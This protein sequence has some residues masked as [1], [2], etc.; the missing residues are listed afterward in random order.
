MSTPP[1]SA[2]SSTTSS[3]IQLT[4]VHG[5]DSLGAGGRARGRLYDLSLGLAPGIHAVIGRPRDGTSALCELIAG[6]ARPRSGRVLVAGREPWKSPALRRRIGAYLARPSLADTG[7]VGRALDVAGMLRGVDVVGLL[8]EVGLGRLL[9]RRMT[10]LHQHEARALDLVLALAVDQPLAVV[11]DEPLD[12]TELIP[13][14]TLVERLRAMATGG[15]AVV[16]SSSVPSDVEGIADH[17]HVIDR[18]RLVASDGALGWP[19]ARERELTLWLRQVADARR[20]ARVLAE[21]PALTGVSWEG[22]DE[23]ATVSVRAAEIEEA[24][25]AIAEA[26]ALTGVEIVGMKP[27]APT[28]ESL[29]LARR[30]RSARG[31]RR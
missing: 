17:L 23:E 8:R 28:L 22:R 26:V 15:T 11:L 3:V 6:R 9:E 25:R 18:G 7:R 16:V 10:S 21:A 27:V 5:R 13:P 1:T 12:V 14:E 31:A 4:R 24:A 30:A 29:H 19:G 20:L 2:P